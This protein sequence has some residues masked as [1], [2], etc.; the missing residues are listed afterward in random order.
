MGSKGNDVGSG[1]A[2]SEGWGTGY[3]GDKCGPYVARLSYIV[4]NMVRT[5]RFSSWRA[6]RLLVHLYGSWVSVWSKDGVMQCS[7]IFV[8]IHHK[9][10]GN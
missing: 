9:P 10:S 4:M 3:E 5:H 6:S 8:L 2:N 7:V 1:M